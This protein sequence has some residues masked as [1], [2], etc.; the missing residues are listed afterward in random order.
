MVQVE[1]SQLIDA[2]S[3]S[4]FIDVFGD[5]DAAEGGHMNQLCVIFICIR[6]CVYINILYMYIH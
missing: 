1:V 6:V 3:L 2:E 4:L 5:A